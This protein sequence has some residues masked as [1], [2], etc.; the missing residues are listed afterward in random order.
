MEL[1]AGRTVCKRCSN[2]YQPILARITKE[3]DLYAKMYNQ[4][5]NQVQK[6]KKELATLKLDAKRDTAY[7]KKL[8]GE[9]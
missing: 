2:I 5:F 1:T 7:I 9:K 4:R 6:L 8:E 3:R